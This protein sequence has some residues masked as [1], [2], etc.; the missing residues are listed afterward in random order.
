MLTYSDGMLQWYWGL[1]LIG[2]V[3]LKVTPLQEI[4]NRLIHLKSGAENFLMVFSF[5]ISSFKEKEERRFCTCFS[6]VWGSVKIPDFCVSI[7]HA[8]RGPGDLALGG[9][10]SPFPSAVF[11]PTFLL[12]LTRHSCTFSSDH[13]LDPML[14]CLDGPEL[15]GAPP[16]PVGAC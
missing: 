5:L 12:F 4:W 7:C 9:E 8:L 13:Q 14:K 1:L 16:G 10:C 3:S 6:V 15:P 2:T 11:T